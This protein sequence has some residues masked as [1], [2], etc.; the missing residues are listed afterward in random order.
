[1]ATKKQQNKYSKEQII[2]TTNDLFFKFNKYILDV[3]LEEGKLY[4]YDEVEVLYK[5]EAE[6]EVV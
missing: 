3:I 1:M 5:K 2:A 6:R 4:S